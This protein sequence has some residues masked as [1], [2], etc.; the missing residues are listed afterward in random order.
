MRQDLLLETIAGNEGAIW[1]CGPKDFRL[2]A[3]TRGYE[4]VR[5]RRPS[6]TT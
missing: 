1:V 6:M 3:V 2:R 4:V 5:L